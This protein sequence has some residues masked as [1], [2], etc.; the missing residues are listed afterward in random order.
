LLAERGI[1]EEFSRGVNDGRP[2]ANMK[3]RILTAPR[4][5]FDRWDALLATM[6]IDQITAALAPS[7]WSTKD[8]MAH[9]MAWQQ[10]ST[11]GSGRAQ[12]GTRFSQMASRAGPRIGR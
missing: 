3:A 8:V 1:A 12:S 7:T 9:L 11:N 5:L 6:S 2:I 4:E 10:R